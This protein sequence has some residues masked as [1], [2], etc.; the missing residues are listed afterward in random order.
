[1]ETATNTFESIFFDV[2]ASIPIDARDRIIKYWEKNN[3]QPV[4]I[5]KEIDVQIIEREYNRTIEFACVV[6]DFSQIFIL[7]EYLLKCAPFPVLKALVLSLLS[8]SFLHAKHTYQEHLV[9]GMHKLNEANKPIDLYIKS[10]LEVPEDTYVSLIAKSWGADEL[11]AQE[12]LAK[13]KESL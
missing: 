6:G 11:G 10:L 1:M 5:Y 3:V 9:L 8:F 2:L 7:K 13:H 12:W 4:L